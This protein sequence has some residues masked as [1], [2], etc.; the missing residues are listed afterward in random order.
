MK[1]IQCLTRPVRNRWKQ[2]LQMN[3]ICAVLCGVVG[4]AMATPAA[5]K[6][7]GAINWSIT[8]FAVYLF[9][10]ITF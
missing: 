2:P 9:N 10:T 8:P 1:V 7:E 5:A 6:E 3:K 4:L